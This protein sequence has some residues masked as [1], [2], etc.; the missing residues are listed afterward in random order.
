VFDGSVECGSGSVYAS[1]GSTS[2]IV[3]TPAAPPVVMF[4]ASY[5]SR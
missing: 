1:P 4:A 3:T 5:W 2:S